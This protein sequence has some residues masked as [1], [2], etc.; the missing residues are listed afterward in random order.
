MPTDGQQGVAT[1][2]PWGPMGQSF[3]D[4]SA[5]TGFLGVDYTTNADTRWW[6]TA[7]LGPLI[8]TVTLSTYDAHTPITT[9]GGARSQGMNASEFLYLIRG[10]DF[11]K[12]KLSDM[13]IS[14]P[15]FQLSENAT[16]TLYT[17]TDAGTEEISFF[18]TGT[19]Y[20]VITAVANAG[21][22]DTH[23][24]NTGS[25]KFTIAGTAPDRI[26]GMLGQ[27]VK[28][29]VLTG[30]VTMAAPNW[31]TVTTLK[32]EP[33][34][35]TGFAM[36]EDYWV[37]GTSNGPY[38]LDSTQLKFFPVIP[39]IDNDSVNCAGM[40][41]WTFMGVL[42]PLR[43]GPRLQRLGSQKSWGTRKFRFNTSPI[44]GR[45]TAGA[46]STAWFY[47][48]YYDDIAGDTHLLAWRPRQDGDA[49]SAEFVAFPIAKFASTQCK[50]LEYIGTA[51]GARTNPTLVGGYGTNAFYMTIGLGDRE[52]DDTGY[53]Y[54][55]S[56][57]LYLTEMRREPHW[58]KDLDY[59][60]FETANCS[61]TQ[62]ITVKVAIDGGT[63]AQIG[64]A[65]TSN[66]LQRI[67]FPNTGDWKGRRL[68]LQM[69]FATGS[70]SASPQ[71]QGEIKVGFH[72]RPLVVDG[73]TVEE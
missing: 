52:I 55:S 42:I 47:T 26:V 9:N 50:Y 70:S 16:S 72:Y 10:R 40:T 57:S 23:S 66:G 29:N 6:G 53:R 58:W 35:P 51:N 11:A 68:K 34:T 3:E 63:A 46:G 1:W 22:A 61:A 12:L 24:T 30:S 65:I 54:A 38:V 8:N 19:N 32:G 18:M 17:K 39:E 7:C 25:A 62:T 73:V 45:M 33:I 13:T 27:T 60:E 59:I 2:Q 56:G 43:D 15:G 4:T 44:R 69:D 48:A 5:G 64:A 67:R 36:D 71:V 41:T 28:G 21:S 31:V 14:D 49:T 20:E 37:L